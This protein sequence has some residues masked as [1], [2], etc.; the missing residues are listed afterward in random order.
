M[1]MKEL[2]VASS[3]DGA[4]EKVRQSGEKVGLTG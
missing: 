2:E 3:L 4:P 1:K